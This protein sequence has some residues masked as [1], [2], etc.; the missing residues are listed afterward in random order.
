MAEVKTRS[1]ETKEK[2][3]QET[4]SKAIREGATGRI[5]LGVSTV[6]VRCLN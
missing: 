6:S 1:S 3:R 5:V 4:R 2:R